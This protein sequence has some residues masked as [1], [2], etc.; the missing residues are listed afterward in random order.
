M[1]EVFKELFRKCSLV[2]E[3]SKYNSFTMKRIVGIEKKILEHF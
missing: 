2:E 1:Y 3:G